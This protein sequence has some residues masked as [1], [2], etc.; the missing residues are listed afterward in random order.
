M[1]GSNAEPLRI[2]P[3]PPSSEFFEI[4]LVCAVSS[5]LA[6]SAVPPTPFLFSLA[7]ILLASE[8]F[9]IPN[10]C[11]CPT[12]PGLSTATK[13]AVTLLTGRLCADTSG[14]TGDRSRLGGD[15][16]RVSPALFSNIARRFRTPPEAAVEDMTAAGTLAES[17]HG[18][19]QWLQSRR[20][21]V[22][23]VK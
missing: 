3:K 7:S 22:E 19:S 10:S 9:L 11:P 13:L 12:S 4:C 6:E 14:S 23:W 1:E 15:V 20:P 2:V 5:F 18:K 8:A 16:E 17:R 21:P